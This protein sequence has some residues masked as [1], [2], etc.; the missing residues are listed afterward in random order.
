MLRR[1]L[2]LD[3][4]ARADLLRA[5]REI[6]VAHLLCLVRPVGQLVRPSDT[7]QTPSVE[8]VV[9][10]SAR[11][12]ALAEAV[13]IVARRGLTRPQCLVR[14]LA[15]CRLLER[16]GEPGSVLRVG[17]RRTDT[18]FAAH[19]WVEVGGEVLG[20]EAWHVQTFAPIPVSVRGRE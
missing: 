11:A 17:V 9:P 16:S 14:S 15:L 7:T 20:D 5:Q 3:S 6:L 19:A 12:R 13:D 18:G 2:R 10:P 8:P 1:L 4:R